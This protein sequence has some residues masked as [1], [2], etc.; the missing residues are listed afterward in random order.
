[1]AECKAKEAKYINSPNT[2]TTLNIY[3]TIFGHYEVKQIL[4]FGL[5]YV[6]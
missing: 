3:T 1:M 2:L 6:F 4:K 5:K